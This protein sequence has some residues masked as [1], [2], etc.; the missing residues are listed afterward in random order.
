MDGCSERGCVAHP[1]HH[2]HYTSHKKGRHCESRSQFQF[3]ECGHDFR[4]LKQAMLRITSRGR[5]RSMYL[6]RVYGEFV[7]RALLVGRAH[8]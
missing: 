4:S 8:H 3:V 2:G 1:V 6:G 7:T 5:S